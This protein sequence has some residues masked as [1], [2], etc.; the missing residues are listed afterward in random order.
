MYFLSEVLVYVFCLFVLI[1]CLFVFLW[2]WWYPVFLQQSLR[3]V[4]K[5]TDIMA[6]VMYPCYIY[7]LAWLC[8]Y[9]VVK[10]TGTTN[11]FKCIYFLVIGMILSLF[12]VMFLPKLSFGVNIFIL[13]LSLLPFYWTVIS[14][15]TSNLSV[16]FRN[17]YWNK[18][19]AGFCFISKL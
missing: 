2:R 12:W 8:I 17:A 9:Y 7:L 11:V 6:W 4:L 3:I 14:A 10:H 13:V 16:C 1:F 5:S 15:L 18:S 19:M